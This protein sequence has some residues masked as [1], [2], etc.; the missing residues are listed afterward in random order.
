MSE[1]AKDFELSWDEATLKQCRKILTKK[2]V[3]LTRI[4]PAVRVA[5]NK[6]RQEAQKLAP[7]ATGKLRNSFKVQYMDGGRKSQTT[8]EAKNQSGIPYGVFPEFGKGRGWSGHEQQFMRPAQKV[9][10]ERLLKECK[11]ILE[12]M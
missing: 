10:Q 2:Q 8:N 4:A 9:G 1:G 6:A 11:K 3:A 7:R 12:T 5:T